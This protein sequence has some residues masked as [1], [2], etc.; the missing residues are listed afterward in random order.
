VVGR[1]DKLLFTFKFVSEWIFVSFFTE[2][3]WLVHVFGIVGFADEEKFSKLNN[4][5]FKPDT[6]FA[7]SLPYLWHNYSFAFV[8]SFV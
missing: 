8:R 7:C 1:L 6:F 4:I 5:C 2:L 3:L